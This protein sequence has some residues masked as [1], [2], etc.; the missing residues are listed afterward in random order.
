MCALKDNSA[1]LSHITKKCNVQ[2]TPLA[3]FIEYGLPIK[4]KL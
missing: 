2:Y 3:N 4:D 1:F